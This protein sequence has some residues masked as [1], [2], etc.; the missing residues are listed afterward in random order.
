MEPKLPLYCILCLLND[1]WSNET[2]AEQTFLSVS[3]HSADIV[4]RFYRL[5]CCCFLL[6]S[7]TS[8]CSYWLTDWR[9]KLSWAL[10]HPPFKLLYISLSLQ[11]RLQPHGSG[12]VSGLLRLHGPR[13]R[14]GTAVRQIQHITGTFSKSTVLICCVCNVVMAI[15]TTYVFP[16][17]SEKKLSLLKQQIFLFFFFLK[18]KEKT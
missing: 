10:L 13:S 16:V 4:L 7:L 12:R 17:F 5:S 2:K 11:Q 14:P 18:C 3:L 6:R 1:C 9:P 8:C 15:I